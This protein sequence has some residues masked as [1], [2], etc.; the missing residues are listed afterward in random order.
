MANIDYSKLSDEE[1]EAIKSGDYSKLSEETLRML[2]GEKYVSEPVAPSPTSKPAPAVSGEPQEEVG[3][4][5]YLI[6]AAKRGLT[7]TT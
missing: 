5:D 7:G 2:A 6:N 1:L 3:V 4:I